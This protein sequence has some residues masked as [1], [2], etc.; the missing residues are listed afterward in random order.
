MPRRVVVT[1]VGLLSPLGAGCDAHWD[2]LLAARPAIRKLDRL[3]AA[4]FPVD[5]AA[6]VPAEA[7]AAC[8]PRLPRKQLK[9]YN[10]TSTLAMAAALLAAEDAGLA[11]PVPVPERAGIVLATFLIPYPIRDLIRL[12][13]QMEQEEAPG[14][15]DM[16]RGLRLAMTGLNPLDLS[17]KVVPN[18]TAGHIAIQFA[19]KGFCRTVSDGATGGMQAIGQAAALIREGELD[20]AFCGGAE[21]SLEEFIFADLCASDLLARPEDVPAPSCRP[22]GL[23]RAGLV[24]GEGAA[25]LVLEA[26]EHAAARGARARAEVRGFGAA[27]GDASVPGIRESC[28]RAM[29]LALAEA[30]SPRVDLVSANGESSAVNDE[31][32]AAAIRARLPDLAEAGGILAPKA[33]HGMLFSAAAPVETASAILALDHGIVPPTPDGWASDPACGLRLAGPAPRP[34]RLRTALVN[35]LG[36]FGEAVSLVVARGAR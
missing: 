15:I 8:L 27:S 30:G 20:I 4:G 32:E 18:L 17:L 13:P 34:A 9:V 14:E 29:S 3:S 12:L 7:L 26:A 11:A 6:E 21:A 25:V 5:V 10:R 22:F 28:T 1:G 23:G 36:T 16:G 33:A 35:A 2:A 31:A 19:L 24:A